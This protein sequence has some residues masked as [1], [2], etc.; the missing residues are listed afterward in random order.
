MME[1]CKINFIEI[2]KIL[3]TIDKDFIQEIELKDTQL[4]YLKFELS[5]NV[6]LLEEN[7]SKIDSFNNRVENLKREIIVLE[8][9]VLKKKDLNIKFAEK[10]NEVDDL[11]SQKEKLL[12][13]INSNEDIKNK[14]VVELSISTKK[15][16]QVQGNLTRIDMDKKN[17]LIEIDKI[18]K[19]LNNKNKEF[20]QFN[21]GISQINLD[22]SNKEN[23]LNGIVC[24]ISSD[25][26]KL[27]I[28]KDTIKQLETKK[29]DLDI[30]IKENNKTLDIG[31]KDLKDIKESSLIEK[32]KLKQ[33][34]NR[35][36]SLRKELQQTILNNREMIDSNKLADFV[37]AVENDN[38]NS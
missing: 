15:L 25:K 8:D 21:S 3:N 36:I 28:L 29:L 2:S 32:N 35:L 33:E 23:M 22:I 30:Y 26:S 6:K 17:L 10:Q 14:Q 1:D 9:E 37:K 13:D 27:E 31:L 18:E 38:K 7:T 34:E 19:I 24:S 12:L 16:Q 4:K 5:K 20:I 11:I